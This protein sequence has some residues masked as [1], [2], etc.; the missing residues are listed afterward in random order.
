MKIKGKGINFIKTS[1]LK[2]TNHISHNYQVDEEA[3]DENRLIGT[4]D[5]KEKRAQLRQRVL[6]MR[7]AYMYLFES[8][9]NRERQQTIPQADLVCHSASFFG[10]RYSKRRRDFRNQNLMQKSIVQSL[11]IARSEP[12][13]EPCSYNSSSSF[14][15]GNAGTS[16]L[17][18]GVGDSDG[19]FPG[20]NSL[21]GFGGGFGDSEPNTLIEFVVEN[22]RLDFL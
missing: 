9:V 19:F 21:A 7:F 2:P 18:G 1:V 8:D 15:G 17:K 13:S 11:E 10:T 20:N 22:L 5:I 6:K 3:G 14:S 4:I 12:H 16:L